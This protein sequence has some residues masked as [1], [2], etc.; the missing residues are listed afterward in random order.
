VLLLLKLTA[1]WAS[2]IPIAIL[3]G[4]L[5][6][7]CLVPLFGPR[8]GLALSGV[9][10]SV[11]FFLLTYFTLRWFG[12]L[13]SSSYWMIG[14]A[15]LLMTVSFEF[16]FGHL[17]AGK[18]WQELFKAYDLTTGN[19]WV[20]VLLVVAISP[21]AAAR[22]RAHL[23]TVSAHAAG[24]LP[25]PWDEIGPFYRP[26][27]PLRGSIGKGYLISGTVRSSLDCSA[28]PNARI[29]VWQ[30]GPNGQYDD[31]HRATLI[32]DREGN[33]RLETSFPKGYGARPP[34]IHIL[35][36]AKGFEGLITQHYPKQGENKAVLD[37]VLAPESKDGGA[38]QGRIGDLVRPGGKDR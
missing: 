12:P 19:L 34:H 27:A 6:E 28:I 11:L 25:T 30:T 32:A 26:N 4:L 5:R 29:E 23:A 33:Y 13:D 9:C 18:S 1:I 16:I 31:A 17:V 37:L 21:P 7:K 20:L 3:N 22:L 35:V 36:D 38:P 15:W 24:C 10:G 14:L 8:P 2:F